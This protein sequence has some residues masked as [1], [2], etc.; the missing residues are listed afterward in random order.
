MTKYTFFLTLLFFAAL[1]WLIYLSAIG[2]IVAMLILAVL[3]AISLIL[4]GVGITLLANHIAS[5]REQRHFMTN[6]KENLMLIRQT[7]D[8]INAQNNQ[9]WRQATQQARL[10]GG[11]S[12]IIIDES[13]FADFDR[14]KREFDG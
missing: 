10:P 12:A 4:T 6:A 9:L 8:L 2:N 3:T 13:Q 11:D 14:D 7:Q 1:G 5:L